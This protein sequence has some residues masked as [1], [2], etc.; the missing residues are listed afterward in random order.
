MQNVQSKVISK[1]Y[2][3]HMLFIYAYSNSDVQNEPISKRLLA[4][5][6]PTT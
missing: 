3:P 4:E 1:Y 6:V 2:K 5:G